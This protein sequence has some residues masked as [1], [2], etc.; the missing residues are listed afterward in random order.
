MN[1][2]KWSQFADTYELSS[3]FGNVD[4]QMIL[5]QQIKD[6]QCNLTGCPG[7]PGG[8]GTGMYIWLLSLLGEL[9]DPG[10]PGGPG[11]P[12]GPGKPGRA[13]TLWAFVSATSEL[14]EPWGERYTILRFEYTH[15]LIFIY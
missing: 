5:M 2:T 13:F 4:G 11:G 1:P 3:L 15:F 8:P 12:A 9:G 10:G 14:L 6:E 7:G